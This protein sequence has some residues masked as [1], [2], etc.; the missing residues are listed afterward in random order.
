MIKDFLDPNYTLEIF[1]G[2]G[3]H[4]PIYGFGVVERTEPGNTSVR[5][6]F[7]ALHVSFAAIAVSELQPARMSEVELAELREKHGLGESDGTETED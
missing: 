3:V 2:Q 4:H 6:R 1:E 7:S 5:V